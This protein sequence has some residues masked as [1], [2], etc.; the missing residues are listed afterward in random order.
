MKSHFKVGCWERR[1]L[2][3]V[4]FRLKTIIKT[5]IQQS[6]LSRRI[7]F[8]SKISLPNMKIHKILITYRIPCK[9]QKYNTPRPFTRSANPWTT[10]KSNNPPTLSTTSTTLNPTMS[11]SK[12]TT[13]PHKSTS[14]TI[15]SKAKSNSP[16][17]VDSFMNFHF[18]QWVNLNNPNYFPV[19]IFIQ[20]TECSRRK[21]LWTVFWT[22]LR[23][24]FESKTE[25]L[26]IYFL[27]LSL[28]FLIET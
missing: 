26:F 4:L 14:T 12:K 10:K 21:R 20:L 1:W 27:F 18:K 22:S 23:T 28:I 25:F 17:A 11:H 7:L 13:Y 19:I 8:M 16:K 2:A 9:L 6:K 3:K 5:K 15:E 24:V